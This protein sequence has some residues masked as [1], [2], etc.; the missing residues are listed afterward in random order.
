[1]FRNHPW[2]GA[3]LTGEPFITDNV[4]NV[5]MNS[6]SFQAA[7]R[8][9][10]IADVLTNYVWLHWIYLGLVWGV[11]MFAGALG[12]A[13][14][15]GRAQRALLLGRLDHPGPGLRRLCRTQDLG[16]A[17]DRGRNLDPG[18][19]RSAPRSTSG[20]Y[21]RWLMPRCRRGL[22]HDIATKTTRAPWAAGLACSAPAP[23]AALAQQSTPAQQRRAPR[24]MAVGRLVWRPRRRHR[25]RHCRRCRPPSTPPSRPAVP[26]SSIIP[27]GTYR[28][29]PHLAVP[30]AARARS[31]DITRNHGILAHGA[32]LVS[33]ITD[34]GNVLEF[35]SHVHRP[36][37]A[38]RRPRHPRQRPR[39]PRHPA[40]SAST[41]STTSTI[42]ACATSSVQGCGGDGCRMMGNVFEGQIINCLPARQQAQRPD[43]RPWR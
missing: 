34:G 25:R 41:R 39:G 43:P 42:S 18:D 7:W 4:M 10:R 40:S 32:R 20:R 14:P 19:A 1:M 33:A 36:L 21:R 2:A 8:I 12:L 5:Y 26:A 17:A 29:T 13:A 30:L 38:A 11:V 16:G 28:I 27:P 31:G 22:R 9:S 15:A 6:P 24:Q 35:I 23:L 3:G 37:P